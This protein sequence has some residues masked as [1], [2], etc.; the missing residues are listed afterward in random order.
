MVRVMKINKLLVMVL[1]V[2]L[3]AISGSVIASENIDKAV[4]ACAACHGANGVSNNGQWPNLA[5]QKEQYLISQINAFRNGSRSDALM[6][7]SVQ[8][9]SDKQVAAIARYFSSLKRE[10]NVPGDLALEGLNVRA[11]CVSCH[12]MKGR[13]VNTE[14]PNLAG[15][16]YEYVK[17]Q[18]MDFKSGA[19]KS[20]IMEV[21]A[22]ELNDEQI[23]AVADHYSKL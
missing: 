3:M 23:A 16:K 22:N 10:Q 2:L 15:Q 9:L 18:L 20:P 8:G 21:I 12:G 17:K 7:A 11:R 1:T 5:G 14:W 4:K 13:T 6:N 19:R